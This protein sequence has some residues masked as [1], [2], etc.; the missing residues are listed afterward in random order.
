MQKSKKHDDRDHRCRRLPEQ[1]LREWS[2]LLLQEDRKAEKHAT[3][4]GSETQTGVWHEDCSRIALA[5]RRVAG[6]GGCGAAEAGDGD[7]VCGGARGSC[8]GGHGRGESG[9]SFEGRLG[10]AGVV[11]TTRVY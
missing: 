1:V 2:K 10:T 6:T 5:G 3:E 9:V 7:G 8:C 4:Q 11:L